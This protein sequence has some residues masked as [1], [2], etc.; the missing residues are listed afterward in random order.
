M[1][2]LQQ[3]QPHKNKIGFVLG[4]GRSRLYSDPKNFKE[5]GIVYGCNA[6]YREFEPDH[7]IVVTDPLI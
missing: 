3:K 5:Q 7:L 1:D 6:L 2:S 4:N